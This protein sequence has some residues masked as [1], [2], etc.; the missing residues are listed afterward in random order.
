MENNRGLHIFID[1]AHTPNA[2]KSVLSNLRSKLKGDAKLIVV[3]GAA[4]LRDASKRPIMGKYASE[5]ANLIVLT[6]EDPR[7]EDP[8][9]I[10]KEIMG[11]V[12]P[13]YR[14]KITIE[15]DRQKAI[16]YAIN[17]LAT[18]GDYVVI[19]GKGHEESMNLNGFTETPWSDQ[20]AVLNT[21]E[22]K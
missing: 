1:F 3:F 7:F 9:I 18:R 17:K 13:K 21:L 4:G 20:K 6:A 11:G 19:C 16:D 14:K 8:A 22:A 5:L 15:L 12:E 10:A 2:L